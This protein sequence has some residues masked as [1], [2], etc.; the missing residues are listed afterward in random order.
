QA[1]RL[2]DIPP[3]EDRSALAAHASRVSFVAFTPDGQTVVSAGETARVWD[4]GT[5]AERC[6]LP[7]RFKEFCA[8]ALSPEGKT[9]IASSWGGTT[10]WDL[11]TTKALRSFGLPPG[12][13]LGLALSPDGKTLITAMR[14]ETHSTD[15]PGRTQNELTLEDMLRLCDVETGK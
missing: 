2:I 13:V 8:A 3:R 1:I 15:R 4:A 10:L 7:A 11:E 5:G 9:L 6:A 14:R 12:H